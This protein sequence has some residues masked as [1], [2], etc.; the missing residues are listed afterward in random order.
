[1]LPSKNAETTL[2]AELIRRGLP[3]DYAR[4]TAEELD[5][6]RA[7]LIADL[8]ADN[9]A[10]PEAIADK[11]LGETRKLAKRIA[12]DYRRRSWFGRWP[13]LSF[14]IAPIPMLLISWA[15][16]LCGVWLF[17]E[18]YD[19][20]SPREEGPLSP[21]ET[22]VVWFFITGVV[23]VLFFVTPAAIA[24]CYGGLALRSTQKRAYVLAVCLLI[25]VANGLVFH[26]A[27]LT[28]E[29][30]ST[31]GSFSAGVPL[32]NEENAFAGILRHFAEPMAMSQLLTPVLVGGVLLFRDERRRRAALLAPAA[33]ADR[34]LLAA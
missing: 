29:G 1:M 20:V 13:L 5:D 11:R 28:P 25:G 34:L 14:L 3:A 31:H 16:V 26:N 15:G 32:G 17:S 18:A 22:Q 24:W 6:H 9:A 23:G 2:Y 4:R 27:T 7:D 33:E 19:L 21:T 12:G 8:R 30:G 10:D